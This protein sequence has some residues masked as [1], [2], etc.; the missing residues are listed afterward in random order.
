MS[1]DKIL[2]TLQ[3]LG[4]KQRAQVSQRFFKTGPGE[5]GE[6]DVFLGIRVPELRR[7]AREYQGIPLSTVLRLLRSPFHEARLLALLMLVRIYARGDEATKER[8]Y[9]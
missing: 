2:S 7:V 5:Y 4:N 1:L 3:S 9:R 8:V 6:G